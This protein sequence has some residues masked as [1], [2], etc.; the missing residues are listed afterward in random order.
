[1]MVG[2]ERNRWSEPE[3]TC[4]A[5]AGTLRGDRF[6]RYRR[7]TSGDD[8]T[9]ED[10]RASEG[11]DRGREREEKVQL[12]GRKRGSDRGSPPAA[13][14]GVA[15]VASRGPG[16]CID[17]PQGRLES[18]KREAHG[19]RAGG[20]ESGA[21]GRRVF[22]ASINQAACCCCISTSSVQSESWTAVPLLGRSRRRRRR[23][24][25]S[26]SLDP[27]CPLRVPSRS[28]PGGTDE[29]SE[30]GRVSQEGEAEGR[31]GGEGEGGQDR[32]GG[33]VHV[34]RVSAAVPVPLGGGRGGKQS[35]S[36]TLP[37]TESRPRSPG[38]PVLALLVRVR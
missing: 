29:A 5:R 11:M 14:G 32:V 26:R 35:L 22:P 28:V 24:R 27:L 34:S 12:C 31:R 20:H 6:R 19:R 2:C 16:A 1:M 10:R 15:V 4:V 21:A 38:C 8:R 30:V 33:A 18:V 9:A 3:R 7:R 36:L 23:R 37:G 13:E 25:D 17:L